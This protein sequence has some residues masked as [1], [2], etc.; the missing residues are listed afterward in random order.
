MEKVYNIA[1][2]GS[3]PGGYVAAIRA[4]Q[5]GLSVCLIEKDKLGGVCLN[6]GCI[7]TK[8]LIKS[9]KTLEALKNS[10]ALGIKADNFSFDFALC[11]QRKESV[12]EA[13]RKGIDFILKKRGVDL[14]YGFGRIK[15]KNTIDVEGKNVKFEN[16]IIAVGSRPADL[17]TIKFDEGK[18]IISSN[19]ILKLKDI[20]KSLLIIGGGVIGCE[21]AYIFSCLGSEVS[22][23]ELTEQIVPTEDAEIIRYLRND[24]KKRGIKVRTKSQATLIDKPASGMSEVSLDSGEK[25]KADKILLSVG[26]KSNTEN[27]GIAELG[28]NLDKGRILVNERMQTNID[29]FYAIGDAVGRTYLA[30]VASREGINAVE[31]ITGK[32]SKIDYHNVPRCMYTNPQ[33]ASVGLQEGEAKEK[34]IDVKIGRFPFLASGKAVVEKQT[35]GLVKLIINSKDDKIIGA[36]IC[37]A[38][39]TELIHEICVAMAAGISAKVLSEVIHA[40]PT[41]SESIMEAAEAVEGEA[42]HIL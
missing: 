22:I 29:N 8:A 6:Q 36:A 7:P 20:P 31:N 40:H 18:G 19:D 5:L 23:V 32:N 12:V 3:G 26:R 39:A 25:I 24:F 11:Q 35:Q 1:V 38:L 2:L 34:G 28:I 42:I 4:A 14:I 13:L 33:V 10:A 16:C 37:G 15:D 41:L 21:F 30:H 27:C 17:R 9:A